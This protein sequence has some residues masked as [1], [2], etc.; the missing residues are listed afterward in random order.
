MIGV[1][2]WS[3]LSAR[4]RDQDIR[5]FFRGDAAFA[6]PELYEYLEDDGYLYAIRL[7]ANAVLEREIEP[8]LTRPVGR[9]PRRPIV[10]Y[11]DFLYQ[12]ASW[13]T[14]P[15]RGGEDRV[16][17]GRAVSPRGLHRDEPMARS[18]PS[19]AV[20]TTVAARPSSGS[21]RARTR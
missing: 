18:R 7:P 15:A 4:Y 17:R 19:G 6:R 2:C 1:R 13:N 21:R 16:A 11:H 9:P 10:W 20:P 12:A 14:G 5:R 3:P 8:F